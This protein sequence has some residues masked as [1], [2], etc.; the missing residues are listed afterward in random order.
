[1][2]YIYL[3]TLQPL[4][5]QHHVHIW[6]E[7]M[8]DHTVALWIG[9]CTWPH[10][11]SLCRWRSIPIP[12]QAFVRRRRERKLK[13]RTCN[14]RNQAGFFIFYTLAAVL[15]GIPLL[16][17]ELYWPVG[18]WASGSKQSRC[19]QQTCPCSTDSRMC[20]GAH[21]H[22]WWTTVKSQGRNR[23]GLHRDPMTGSLHICQMK[24][25]RW[26]LGWPDTVLSLPI[27]YP[28]F[29]LWYQLK[30]IYQLSADKGWCILSPLT[31]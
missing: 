19:L 3:S 8:K 27:Q 1:M 26:V 28:Y 21:R 10:V 7:A 29:R 30:P 13:G 16:G 24:D 9:A 15:S 5:L 2:I 6:T 4:A 23:H 25:P 12:S 22:S 18:E 17:R 14:L 11:E 20:R 31:L